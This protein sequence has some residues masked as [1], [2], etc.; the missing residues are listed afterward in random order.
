MEY[1]HVGFLL[2]T[3]ISAAGAADQLG[4]ALHCTAKVKMGVCSCTQA[5]TISIQCWVAICMLVFT[6]QNPTL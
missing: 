1:L 2:E 5:R 6:G 3:T 4:V